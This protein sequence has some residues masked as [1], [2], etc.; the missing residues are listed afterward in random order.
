MVEQPLA[1]VT[2]TVYKP[3]DVTFNVALIPK[4]LIPFDH[5][6]DPPPVAVRVIALLI[7]V[8]SVIGA[9]IAGVGATIFWVID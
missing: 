7:H 4:T 5:E 9:L 2:V 8:K 3:G 1:P 6:Y